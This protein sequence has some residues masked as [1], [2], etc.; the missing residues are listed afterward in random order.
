MLPIEDD[1]LLGIRRSAVYRTAVWLAR[2]ANLVLLPVV[3]WGIVSVAQIAPTLPQPVFMGAWAVGCVTLVPAVLL[4]YRSG[5]PFGRRG[6]TWVTDERVGNAILR[7]V[8][9]LRR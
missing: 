4:F 2:V 7:D 8:F 6:L 9:W 3:V 1:A 5:I